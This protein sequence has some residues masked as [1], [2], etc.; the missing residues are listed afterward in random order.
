MKLSASGS[1]VEDDIE[2]NTNTGLCSEILQYQLKEV[3]L[4]VQKKNKNLFS[5]NHR[6]LTYIINLKMTES[7]KL[8]EL[9]MGTE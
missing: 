5:L 9:K 8:R 3:F 7:G 2:E 4:F 6:N 1:S